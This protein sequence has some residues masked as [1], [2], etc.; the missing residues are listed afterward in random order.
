MRKV[1]RVL[2]NLITSTAARHGEILGRRNQQQR[3]LRVPHIAK[4]RDRPF[5]QRNRYR[6]SVGIAGSSRR[7]AAKSLAP[8]RLLRSLR[9][10]REVAIPD[11]L[12]RNAILPIG[13]R[14]RLAIRSSLHAQCVQD[15]ALLRDWTFR[16]EERHCRS[17][18]SFRTQGGIPMV[19]EEFCRTAARPRAGFRLC[20]E[21]P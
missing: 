10:R 20:A 15:G 7:A 4:L 13:D 16:R 1:I 21:H 8:A 6:R 9:N 3:A 18:L 5:A 12:S 2:R 17:C 19:L 14:N 11:Q